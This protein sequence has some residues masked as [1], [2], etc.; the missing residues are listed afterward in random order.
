MAIIMKNEDYRILRKLFQRSLRTIHRA[1]HE[2]LHIIRKWL[3]CEVIKPVN[4]LILLVIKDSRARSPFFDAC[5]G[6]INGTHIPISISL[7]AIKHHQKKPVP[8][9][10]R[11]HKG[12]YSQNIFTYINFNRNFHFILTRWEGSAYNSW[13]I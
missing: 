1:F 11:N 6:A 12:Y 8:A 4:N 2:V 5:R 7:R 9:A 13:V 3:Y 10:W